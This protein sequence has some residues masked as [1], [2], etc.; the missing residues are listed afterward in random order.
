VLQR[1][2]EQAG[3]LAVT[4]ASLPTVAAPLGAARMAAADTPLGAALG[5]PGGAAQ[6]R[7]ILEAAIGVLSSA[8]VAGQVEH[9]AEV[10]R[11]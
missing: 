4:I 1:A 7:R 10:Y 9:I 3:L 11:P 8:E 6:Q 2:V 5:A